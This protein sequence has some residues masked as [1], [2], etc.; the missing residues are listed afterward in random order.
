[1]CMSLKSAKHHALL[2]EDLVFLAAE[3]HHLYPPSCDSARQTLRLPPI[4]PLSL[5]LS[6]SQLTEIMQ[7]MNAYFSAIHRQRGKG[8]DADITIA[9]S[10]EVGFRHLRSAPTPT[11][12]ELPSHP[13][14]EGPI[15]RH[16]LPNPSANSS[17]WPPVRPSPRPQDTVPPPLGMA[18]QPKQRESCFHSPSLKINPRWAFQLKELANVGERG[19]GERMRRQGFLFCKWSQ[20]PTETN[21]AAD[22][23]SNTLPPPSPVT[24]STRLP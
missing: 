20:K 22:E 15:P 24:Q 9:D 23:V 4:W 1:M 3:W 2:L 14:W 10:T 7:L 16:S 12:L 18:Q 13:V 6:P 8:E 21:T 5:S 19:V 11:L 17:V